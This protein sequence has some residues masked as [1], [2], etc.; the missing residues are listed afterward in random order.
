MRP[1]APA[2]SCPAAAPLRV[3]AAVAPAAAFHNLH[4]HRRAME[5]LGSRN[6]QSLYTDHKYIT[7]ATV[8]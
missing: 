7:G 2:S 3:S 1:S 8:L 4:A 6:G 5:F